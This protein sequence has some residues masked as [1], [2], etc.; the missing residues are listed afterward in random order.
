MSRFS[1]LNR[2]A[3]YLKLKE[4]EKEKEKKQEE[5]EEEE[6]EEEEE[7]DEK[8]NQNIQKPKNIPITKTPISPKT[9]LNRLEKQKSST[10]TNTS[11]IPYNFTR[12][13][14][15]Y[16]SKNNKRRNNIK[17]NNNKS[18]RRK[19]KRIIFFDI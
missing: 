14:M 6:I 12:S 16:T 2:R 17:R 4:K 11:Q 9:S 15:N 7:Q 18:N 3:E 19:S 5:N 1:T 13:R 10:T 8:N